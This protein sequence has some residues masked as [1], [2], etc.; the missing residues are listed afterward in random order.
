MT[1][2]FAIVGLAAALAACG[3]EPELEQPSGEREAFSGQGTTLPLSAVRHRLGINA[4]RLGHSPGLPEAQRKKL[5]DK[6]YKTGVGLVRVDMTW[7]TV[8]TAPNVL[9]F[10]LTDSVVEQ[11]RAGAGRRR[12]Q[13]LAILGGGLPGWTKGAFPRYTSGVNKGVL[14]MRHYK[15]FVRAFVRRYKDDIDFYT[16]WNEPNLNQRFQNGFEW[17]GPP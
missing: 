1:R 14:D 8:E 16:P 10:T 7:G 12:L 6:L 2:C 17:G 13:I 4:S 9:D 15:A 11:A 5:Q 3:P